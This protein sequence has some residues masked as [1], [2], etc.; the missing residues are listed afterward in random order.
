HHPKFDL[1]E[2]ALPLGAAILSYTAI[3]FLRN[4]LE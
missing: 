3:K 4:P 2:K 1:D